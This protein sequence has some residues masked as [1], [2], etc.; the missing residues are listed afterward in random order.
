MVIII[1]LYL[2]SNIF[3]PKSQIQPCEMQ[4]NYDKIM[5]ISRGKNL[6]KTTI[7]LK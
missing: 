6:L 4:S 1:S 7:V 2:Y 3:P 5:I